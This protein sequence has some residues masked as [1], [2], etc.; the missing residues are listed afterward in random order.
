MLM[1]LVRTAVVLEVVIYFGGE[2]LLRPL[3]KNIDGLDVFYV[4][5]ELFYVIFNKNL[6]HLL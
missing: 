4:Y 5:H 6:L 3:S 1:V 2:G